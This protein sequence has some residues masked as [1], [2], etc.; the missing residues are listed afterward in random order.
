MTW[1]ETLGLVLIVIVMIGAVWSNR[2]GTAT[3]GDAPRSNDLGSD[4]S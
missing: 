3:G 4:H 1:G 2:R